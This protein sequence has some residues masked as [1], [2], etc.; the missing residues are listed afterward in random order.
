MP[1]DVA[2]K[3]KI[4]PINRKSLYALRREIQKHI[5]GCCPFSFHVRIGFN[6]N[7][8]FIILLDGKGCCL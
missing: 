8:V 4:M 5:V 3:I 6:I 7:I 1:W 2:N